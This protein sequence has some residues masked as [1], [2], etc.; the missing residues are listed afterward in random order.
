VALERPRCSYRIIVETESDKSLTGTTSV[1]KKQTSSPKSRVSPAYLFYSA[2]EEI[3]H[4]P[5]GPKDAPH[6][7][8]GGTLLFFRMMGSTES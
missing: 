3:R 4:A 6:L 2:M 1:G 5:L 7:R 8:G